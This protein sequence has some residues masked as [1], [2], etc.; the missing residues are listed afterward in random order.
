[1][2]LNTKQRNF[3]WRRQ[4]REHILS[5]EW[6]DTSLQ[7]KWLLFMYLFVYSEQKVNRIFF[8]KRSKSG[9]RIKLDQRWDLLK[10]SACTTLMVRSL[11]VRTSLL[12]LQ[13]QSVHPLWKSCLICLQSH[14]AH[15]SSSVPSCIANTS[16]SPWLAVWTCFEPHLLLPLGQILGQ[17]HAKILLLISSS[18]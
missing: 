12:C 9:K 2:E 11:L 17:H 3:H 16:L 13:G 10:T 6:I 4:L 7:L 8:F 18:Y 15:L 5:E 14:T 1:M